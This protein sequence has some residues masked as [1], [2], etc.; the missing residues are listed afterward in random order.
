M[1]CC[2]FALDK[3]RKLAAPVWELVGQSR[4][5]PDIVQEHRAR[6]SRA[7]SEAVRELHGSEQELPHSAREMWQF[8]WGGAWPC[9]TTAT[10]VAPPHVAASLSVPLVR[11][12]S[13]ADGATSS[14]VELSISALMMATTW[15]GYLWVFK[16][17]KCGLL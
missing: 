5:A 9:R 1:P 15:S 17:P 8:D 12:S 4:E 10:V 6:S 13:A 16:G 7:D 3:A 14:P 11:R 2:P